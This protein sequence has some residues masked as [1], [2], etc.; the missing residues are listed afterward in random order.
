MGRIKFPNFFNVNQP[1]CL[2]FDHTWHFFNPSLRRSRDT[3]LPPICFTSTSN[4]TTTTTATT[5]ATAQS[6]NKFHNSNAAHDNNNQLIFAAKIPLPTTPTDSTKGTTEI[7]KLQ[8]EIFASSRKILFL[9]KTSQNL[10]KHNTST[11]RATRL[12]RYWFVKTPYL[13]YLI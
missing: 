6:R 9:I 8:G 13:S 11:S 4:N 7:K 10:S 5:T 1:K 2:V 3:V 12:S